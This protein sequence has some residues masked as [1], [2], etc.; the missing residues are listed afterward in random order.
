M[1]RWHS[2]CLYLSPQRKRNL[3]EMRAAGIEGMPLPGFKSRLR[4][5]QNGSHG[6]ESGL[7][8]RQDQS[9]RR[10][11]EGHSQSRVWVGTSFP[12]TINNGRPEEQCPRVHA[13]RSGL[14]KTSPNFFQRSQQTKPVLLWMLQELSCDHL[15]VCE[16]EPSSNA[17]RHDS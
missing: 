17:L 11:Y 1:E 4:Q 5:L 8:H 7:G 15:Q 13:L 3:Y 2:V 10:G 9:G 14:G 6:Q 16:V 12:E